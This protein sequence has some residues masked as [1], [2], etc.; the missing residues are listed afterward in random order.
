MPSGAGFG[1]TGH[2]PNPGEK[3]EEARVAWQERQRS[4]EAERLREEARQA[5]REEREREGQEGFLRRLARILR[6]KRA[7]GIDGP[8]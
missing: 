4:L 7:R 1:G 3:Y 8:G 2:F 5:R 6:G